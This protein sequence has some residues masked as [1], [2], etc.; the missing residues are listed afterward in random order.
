[1]IFFF[2]FRNHLKT[3]SIAGSE[4]R[5]RVFW[6]RNPL[7]A[8]WAQRCP[9]PP[10]TLKRVSL[11]HEDIPRHHHSHSRQHQELSRDTRE[12]CSPPS[13]FKSHRLSQQRPLS[14]RIRLR[15]GLP[16]AAISPQS[17]LIWGGFSV[18][19]SPSIEEEEPV[20]LE[21]I[22]RFPFFCCFLAARV[23]LRIFGREFTG[24]MLFFS[25]KP[26]RQ[27]PDLVLYIT[28]SPA[29]SCRVMTGL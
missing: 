19:L 5:Q 6:V 10:Q 21:T 13:P 23:R 20:I 26:I 25:L 18:F 28:D 9:R 4:V 16:L 7:R 29:P 24:V 22:P 11:T 1:M 8:S 17:P 14:P 12:P 15:V 3:Y 2:K 27:Q